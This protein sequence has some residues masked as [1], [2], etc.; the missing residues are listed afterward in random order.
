VS[1]IFR[2]R[3]SSPASLAGLQSR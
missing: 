1:V 3:S 2:E